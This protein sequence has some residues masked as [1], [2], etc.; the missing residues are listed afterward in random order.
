[1]CHMG[2]YSNNVF[3]AISFIILRYGLVDRR[4][5]GPPPQCPH[6]WGAQGAAGKARGPWD[7]NY[8]I[9]L[10]VAIITFLSTG[11]RASLAE[12]SSVRLEMNVLF[13]KIQ[14]RPKKQCSRHPHSFSNLQ[15]H[16]PNILIFFCMIPLAFF[17]NIY[18]SDWL[19]I[20]D[21]SLTM[22]VTCS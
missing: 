19:A 3:C 11:E 15:S 12:V 8:N 17:K 5:A 20:F 14:P 18:C 10:V 21:G 1:M 13:R 7:H 16:P 22:R 2:V 9:S 6:L 4:G